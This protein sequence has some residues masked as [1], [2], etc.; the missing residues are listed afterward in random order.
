MH[1]L[2]MYIIDVDDVSIEKNDFIP[3]LGGGNSNHVFNVHANFLRKMISM[4]TC[5]LSCSD[6]LGWW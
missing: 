3:Y 5:A 6:G 1:I 2:I 4:L